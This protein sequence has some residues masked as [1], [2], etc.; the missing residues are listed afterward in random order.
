M[1]SHNGLIRKINVAAIKRLTIANSFPK[2]KKFKRIIR[3]P[4]PYIRYQCF[5]P[6]SYNSCNVNKLRILLKKRSLLVFKTTGIFSRYQSTQYCPTQVGSPQKPFLEPLPLFGN[7]QRSFGI[8]CLECAYRAMK[9]TLL[10]TSKLTQEEEIN[11]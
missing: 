6:S 11:R 7:V 5:T 8:G 2:N 9:P 4:K 10:F 3:R 1:L